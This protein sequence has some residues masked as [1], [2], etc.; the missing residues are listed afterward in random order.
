MGGDIRQ[1]QEVVADTRT[2]LECLVDA[3]SLVLVERSDIQGTESRR[4][5]TLAALLHECA[6]GGENLRPGLLCGL[7]RP[8]QFLPRLGIGEAEIDARVHHGLV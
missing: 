8:P 6:L 2:R 7:R 5:T 4:Q 1:P 3:T